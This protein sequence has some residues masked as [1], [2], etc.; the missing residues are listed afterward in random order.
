MVANY[1][2]KS[3]LMKAQWTWPLTPKPGRRNFVNIETIH[4]RFQLLMVRF[5]KL[6]HPPRY[7]E[8]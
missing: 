1:R 7:G 4:N 2:Q 5:I 6:I 8:I 3:G